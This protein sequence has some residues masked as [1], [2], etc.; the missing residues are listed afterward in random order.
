MRNGPPIRPRQE[1][2]ALRIS[3]R[4]VVLL[5]EL[6]SASLVLAQRALATKSVKINYRKQDRSVLAAV[7]R[8]QCVYSRRQRIRFRNILDEMSTTV[9]LNAGSDLHG[10]PPNYRGAYSDMVR[11][12]FSHHHSSARDYVRDH[13]SSQ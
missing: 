3:Y 7:E 9:P 5:V 12:K 2:G 11:R 6:V 8:R 13:E 4:Q 10:L 1:Q